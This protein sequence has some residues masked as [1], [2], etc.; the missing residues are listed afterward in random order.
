[1]V[2]WHSL[3]PF[4]NLWKVQVANQWFLI[5]WFSAFPEVRVTN[6]TQVFEVK[7][8]RIGHGI[9]LLKVK[10]P[11]KQRFLFSHQNSGVIWV[12]GVYS[13]SF[14]FYFRYIPGSCFS[15][16]FGF[17]PSKRSFSTLVHLCVFTAILTSTVEISGTRRTSGRGCCAGWIWNLIGMIASILTMI[18]P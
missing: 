14:L 10:V 8:L 4:G 16:V 5:S 6:S 18:N 15:S 11:P 7:D 3:K 2:N 17:E 9:F 12:L 13:I 1:M